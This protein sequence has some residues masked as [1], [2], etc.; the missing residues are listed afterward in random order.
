VQELRWGTYKRVRAR[1]IRLNRGKLGFD[2]SLQLEHGK[3]S[4]GNEVKI[5]IQFLMISK[6]N[7]Y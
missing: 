1:I 7:E 6:P 4:F 2:E 3:Y 5:E